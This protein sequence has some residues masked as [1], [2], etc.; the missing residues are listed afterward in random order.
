MNQHRDGK[1][2]D[3]NAFTLLEVLFV[4]LIIGFLAAGSLYRWDYLVNKYGRMVVH[5]GVAELNSRETLVWAKVVVS[6]KGWQDDAL[7]FSKLDK[8]LGEDYTWLDHGPDNHG[9]RISF[10]DMFTFV[11]VRLPSTATSPGN[12]RKHEP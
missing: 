1:F 7:L 6:D 3:S 4:L 8:N 10:Q 5:A 12:W 2:H 9:G 11:L